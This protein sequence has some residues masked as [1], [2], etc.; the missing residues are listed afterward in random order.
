M[1]EKNNKSDV[2]LGSESIT[3][4]QTGKSV[5]TEP[6]RNVELQKIDRGEAMQD[7]VRIEEPQKTEAEFQEVNPY[8]GTAYFEN[9]EEPD[10][11]RSIAAEIDKKARVY[12]RISWIAFFTCC[13][14]SLLQDAITITVSEIYFRYHIKIEGPPNAVFIILI[15]IRPI[16]NL[17]AIVYSILAYKTKKTRERLEVIILLI[18]V[19][20]ANLLFILAFM[21]VIYTIVTAFR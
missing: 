9:F 5:G 14:L 4:I 20:I 11:F 16:L 17:V 3:Y 8:L 15:L 6:A 18:F 1:T 21:W 7:T 19:P 10:K 12:S 13:G 2:D